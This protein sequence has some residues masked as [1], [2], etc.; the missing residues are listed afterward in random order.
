MTPNPNPAPSYSGLPT[1]TSGFSIDAITSAVW[2]HLPPHPPPFLLSLQPGF[3]KGLS[4]L[5]VYTIILH[6]RSSIYRNETSALTLVLSSP[7][8]KKQW[9][10]CSFLQ[11]ILPSF[12]FMALFHS[13][14]L[15]L[16]PYLPGFNFF[17][18]HPLFLLFFRFL[19]ECWCTS[20][21]HPQSFA[22]FT[23][24]IVPGTNQ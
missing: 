1:P 16:L 7:D 9:P 12:C 18:S 4:T 3:F 20:L 10:P 22:V 24:P 23:L 5:S 21:L 15:P 19:I 6:I 8:T 14:P 2:V 13:C 11:C 17:S